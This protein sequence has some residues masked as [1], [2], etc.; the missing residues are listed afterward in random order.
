[1]KF[2]PSLYFFIFGRNPQLSRAELLSYLL[3]RSISIKS[4]Q[5]EKDFLLI[6]VLGSLNF[7]ELT[8]NLAGTVK[9]GK[10][11]FIT[12]ESNKILDSLRQLNFYIEDTKNLTYSISAYGNNIMES[13]YHEVFKQLYKESKQK[14]S[15]KKPTP[16]GLSNALKK[17]NFIDLVVCKSQNQFFFGRTIGAYDIKQN[18]LRYEK[19]PY[20]DESIGSSIRI[21]RILVNLSQK[22]K[23]KLLDP[24]C[25][26]GTILQ[27]A[28]LLSFDVLG[29]D[30]NS[31]R[32]QQCKEN[33]TWIKQQTPKYLPDFDIIQA[34]VKDILFK[35]PP[36][37]VDTVVT[38]PELGPLLKNIPNSREAQIIMDSLERLY[39]IAF[40][41]LD[42]LL[43]PSGTMIFVIPEIITTNNKKIRPS[44]H[45]LIADT[46]LRII[47][48]ISCEELTVFFPI[49]YKEKWHKLGRWIY[50]FHKG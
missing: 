38:E 11:Y 23:G 49:F 42:R 29:T 47:S 30:L 19:R 2:P 24:F 45:T 13:H 9:F 4:H 28:L 31:Q 3:S 40:Y 10:I 12:E 16:S 44:V 25:G 22:V 34:D 50:L 17:H 7:L 27:E 48:E 6:E 26:I 18:K 1:M 35:I 15:L 46:Q 33:L 36:L 43:K 37:S 8:T 41:N 39:C 32:V 20:V 14:A 5:A 21:S